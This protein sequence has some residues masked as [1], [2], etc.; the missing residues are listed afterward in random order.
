MNHQYSILITGSTGFCGTYLSK[1]FKDRNNKFQVYTTSRRKQSNSNH[2]QHDLF[3]PVPI[4]LFPKKIDCII[5]CV[6]NLEH[7]SE[8]SVINDNLKTGFNICQYA[9][10]AKCQHFINFSSVMVYGKTEINLPISENSQTFPFTVYGLS[11]L[12]VENIVNGMLSNFM[13]VTNLRLGKIISHDIPKRYFLTKFKE[14]FIKG[15]PITLIN[16]DKTKC[17][18]IDLHDIAKICELLI[19]TKNKG[20]FNIVNDE[21]PS[22]R[23]VTQEMKKYFNSSSPIKEI[24]KK[25]SEEYTFTYTN[26]KIKKLLGINFKSYHE[27]F[28]DM[29]SKDDI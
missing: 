7:I 1:Y 2:K 27:S 19:D 28:R 22:L 24:L 21:F 4:G 14:L 17:I 18:F 26:K 23:Q 8:F 20:T 29:F 25:R 10:K 15:E 5:H 11:K 12:L 16:P 9:I 13:D 6:G 3:V